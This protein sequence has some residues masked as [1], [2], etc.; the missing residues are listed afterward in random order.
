MI[1]DLNRDGVI[2]LVASSH[3]MEP[4]R[5]AT[6]TFDQTMTVLFQHLDHIESVA[7]ATG[8]AEGRPSDAA[9]LG[10]ATPLNLKLS[11]GRFA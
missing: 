3:W 2:G 8:H 7:R 9:P 11:K 4:R 5:S 1:L 10:N 6:S